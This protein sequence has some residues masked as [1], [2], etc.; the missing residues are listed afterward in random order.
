MRVSGRNITAKQNLVH[1]CCAKIDRQLFQK[2]ENATTA[3][4]PNKKIKIPK[5]AGDKS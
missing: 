5:D 3:D 1:K 4:I 2:T